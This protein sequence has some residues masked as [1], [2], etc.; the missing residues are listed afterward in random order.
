[1]PPWIRRRDSGLTRRSPRVIDAGAEAALEAASDAA[2]HR[3]DLEVHEMTRQNLFSDPWDGDDE[4]LGLG[5]ESSG[6]RTTPE[7]EQRCTNWPPTRL[8]CGC[9]CTSEPKRCS[10]S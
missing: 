6:G 5:I 10:S 1:M 9:T 3:Y 2:C 4:K 8:T 7:W